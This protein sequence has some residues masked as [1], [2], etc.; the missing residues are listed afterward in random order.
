MAPSTAPPA[1]DV[2]TTVGT[3][4]R[5]DGH[6][7]HHAV[8]PLRHRLCILSRWPGDATMNPPS[9]AL[10]H[11][12]R[13]SG[14]SIALGGGSGPGGVSARP[15]CSRHFPQTDTTAPVS[16]CVEVETQATRKGWVVSPPRAVWCR[17]RGPSPRQGRRMAQE[18]YEAYGKSSPLP[19]P[20]HLPS[21]PGY[22]PLP[23]TNGTRGSRHGH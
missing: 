15:L 2:A 9:V 16:G 10:R 19:A 1:E 11:C 7:R 12:H 6:Q 18:A 22:V 23:V 17:D 21:P 20:H 5:G 4:R 8:A 3:A 14:A 13:T